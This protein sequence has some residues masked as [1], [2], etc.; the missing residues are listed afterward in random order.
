[1]H[2]SIMGTIRLYFIDSDL[3]YIEVSFKA[4]LT[5][6]QN[7]KVISK[8]QGFLLQDIYLQ[9]ASPITPAAHVI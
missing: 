2:Y 6:F 1:M 7:F 5:G 3:F 8:I 9:Q 4:G